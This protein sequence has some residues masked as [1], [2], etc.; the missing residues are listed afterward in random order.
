M[1]IL[2]PYASSPPCGYKLWDFWNLMGRDFGSDSL[3]SFVVLSAPS[4]PRKKSEEAPQ[5][6]S[7]PQPH[8][9]HP[10]LQRNDCRRLPQSRPSCRE[11]P[12]FSA[13]ADSERHHQWRTTLGSADFRCIGKFLRNHL[14]GRQ[15]R[16]RHL[17]VDD[18]LRRHL[19]AFSVRQRRLVDGNPDLSIS[20]S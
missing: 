3:D 19:Q 17:K 14:R 12:G 18:W 16:L 1:K 6:A 2:S 10:S 15:R 8:H 11:R 20:K 5:H 4:S 9:F 7:H 13:L